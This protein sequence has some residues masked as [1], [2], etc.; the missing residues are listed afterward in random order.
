MST[1]FSNKI[2]L[3]NIEKVIGRLVERVDEIVNVLST[4]TDEIV[5]LKER[6]END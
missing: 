4:M 5:K 6:N 2:R 1:D 3:E